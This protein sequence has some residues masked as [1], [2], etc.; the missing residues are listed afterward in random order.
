MAAPFRQTSFY[1]AHEALLLPYEEALTRED[2]LTGE[3]SHA[4]T[5]KPQMFSSVDLG[6]KAHALLSSILIQF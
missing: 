5:R 3:Y 2:S 1:T 4:I 6:S